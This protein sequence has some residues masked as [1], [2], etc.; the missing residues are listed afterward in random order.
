MLLADTLAI[1]LTVV[2]FLLAFQS[3][4]LVA[5]ALAPG[6]VLEAQR[7]CRTRP[8]ATLVSGLAITLVAVFVAGALSKA[9]GPGGKVALGLVANFYLA[10]SLAGVAGL[11]SHIGS[12]LPSPAD[13][14]RPWRAT[15]RGGA[16]LEL[17]YLFP[18][19]GW[20]FVL[21]LSLVLGAG[22][23]AL[24]LATCRRRGIGAPVPAP[25]IL[26]ADAA[27]AG[28]FRAATP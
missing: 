9:K 24:G 11:A 2:G 15:L 14:G 20:F 10:L 6:V 12:R 17:S 5:R 16:A 1:F 4:W 23:A 22:A 18:I 7:H 26:A 3:Y 19:L 28:E 27:G 25:S 21:P 13:H 8:V